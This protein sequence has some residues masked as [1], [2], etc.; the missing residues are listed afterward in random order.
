[1]VSRNSDYGRLDPSRITVTGEHSGFRMLISMARKP[2]RG[3]VPD[4][5]KIKITYNREGQASLIQPSKTKNVFGL[6]LLNT[7]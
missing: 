6:N 3:T 2:S 4:R 7:P 1:M 5:K